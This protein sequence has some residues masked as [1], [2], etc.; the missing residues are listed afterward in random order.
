LILRWESE[1]L[2]EV[3]IAFIKS[4]NLSGG[5]MPM[6]WDMIELSELDLVCVPAR[7]YFAGSFTVELRHLEIAVE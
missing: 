3:M 4:N 5:E 6:F 7:R 1:H 2:W